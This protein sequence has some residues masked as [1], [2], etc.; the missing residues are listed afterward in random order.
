MEVRIPCQ[1]GGNSRAGGIGLGGLEGSGSS[2]WVGVEEN[3]I[4][5]AREFPPQWPG[6][7]PLLAYLTL[8]QEAFRLPIG[9]KL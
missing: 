9:W 2:G 6:A 8:S 3:P 4:L 7:T 5:K 1:W